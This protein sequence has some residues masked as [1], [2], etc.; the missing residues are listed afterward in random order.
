MHFWKKTEVS[1]YSEEMGFGLRKWIPDPDTE[2][3]RTKKG[4]ETSE[5]VRKREFEKDKNRGRTVGGGFAEMY[6]RHKKWY[7]QQNEGG[8]NG[9]G[10]VRGQNAG[11][12]RSERKKVRE[13]VDNAAQTSTR[14]RSG[15]LV[16]G[17]V[18]GK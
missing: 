10:V 3:K 12:K 13:K 5:E 17:T 16:T 6:M 15:G 14:E 2:G 7:K 18:H 4:K 11:K 1:E 8:R 9:G